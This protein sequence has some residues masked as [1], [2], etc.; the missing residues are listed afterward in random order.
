MIRK[1]ILS[2][3]I[4]SSSA[5]ASQGPAD[6]FHKELGFISIRPFDTTHSIKQ[7]DTKTANLPE[8]VAIDT[9]FPFDRQVILKVTLTAADQKESSGMQTPPE[10]TAFN[11]C[12]PHHNH[13]MKLKPSIE[14]TEAENSWKVSG[15]KLHM[16][17]DWE[18][19]MTFRKGQK[20]ISLKQS[21]LIPGADS[22]YHDLAD[23][24][25]SSATTRKHDH[26]SRR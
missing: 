7:S 9:V 15:I 2:L 10:L 13:C 8:P 17:G 26:T 5:E 22:R 4:I 23:R 24:K 6:F 12:M 19:S 1:V 16:A 11:L 14:K 18:L 20:E 3:I 25:Q 21:F